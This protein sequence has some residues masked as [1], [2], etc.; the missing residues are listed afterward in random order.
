MRYLGKQEIEDIA[1]GAALLGTGGGGDPY[2]GKLMTLQAIEEYGPIQLL[3][4]DEVPQD[5]LVVSSGM[6]GAPTVMIEKA[7][8]GHEARKA[9]QMLEGFLGQKVFATYPIEA[10]GLNSMLP[11]ALAAQ[12]G[13]PVVDVDGMGR[14]FPE[15][16]MA[17]FYLDGIA[18]TPMAIAD[19]KGNV[20]LIDTIDSLWAE[21]IARSATIQMGGSVM[22]AIYPMKGRQLKES[23]IHNIL[24][25]EEDLGRTIRLA[26]EQNTEPI[27]EI[28]AI[29]NGFELFRGKVIDINRKTETGFARGTASMEGLEEYKGETLKLRFQNEHLIAMT[30]ERLLCVT[31]DLIAVLDA[32]TGVPITTEGLRYGARAVVIGIPCHPKWRTAK[33]IETCGPGYF[34]YD[35]EY[36][37]VEELAKKGVAER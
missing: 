33:G 20:N 27:R 14:A 4:V 19:E 28:L 22:F 36:L 6:M 15:L 18:A 17:T 1:V 7:P 24:K 3:T 31:P 13:L 34:G 37:P 29:T 11:L 12:M 21:R 9:F 8:S 5:A 26:K 2:I 23:G 10:G 35:V 25:L 30:E 32:E 16:Q